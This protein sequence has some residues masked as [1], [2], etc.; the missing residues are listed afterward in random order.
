[1]NRPKKKPFRF[2]YIAE[3]LYRYLLETAPLDPKRKPN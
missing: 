1:M 2:I 3:A